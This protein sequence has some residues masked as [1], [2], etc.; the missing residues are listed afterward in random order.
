LYREPSGSA[1][2]ET[3]RNIL[4]NRFE[5]LEEVDAHMIETRDIGED[6]KPAPDTSTPRLEYQDV[7]L[8]KTMILKDDPFIILIRIHLVLRVS[9]VYQSSRYHIL[10]F[11]T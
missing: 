3:S 7:T 6:N 5:V 1:G 4:H 11:C 8:P 10:M 9:I 2:N